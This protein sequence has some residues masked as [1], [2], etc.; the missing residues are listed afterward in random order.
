MA[1]AAAVAG[2]RRWVSIVR[3]AATGPLTMVA[4]SATAALRGFETGSFWF[5][6]WCTVG[7][8]V[9]AVIGA[10]VSMLRALSAERPRSVW[11]GLATA[12]W[13]GI[14]IGAA[15]LAALC[16]TRVRSRTGTWVS[17]LG[18]GAI[19]AGLFFSYGTI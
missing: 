12:A 14:A 16:V 13:P 8:A 15:V 11:L 9:G 1:A 6:F 7:A 18:I 3:G 2:H 5:V 19:A 4:Y 17:T 10:S